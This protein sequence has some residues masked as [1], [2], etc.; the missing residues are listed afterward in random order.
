MGKTIE[1]IVV[2]DSLEKIRPQIAKAVNRLEAIH[3]IEKAIKN[4]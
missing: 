2:H 4:N 3:C 1:I